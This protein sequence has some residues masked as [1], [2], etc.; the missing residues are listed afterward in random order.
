[1]LVEL[2]VRKVKEK[3]AS[4]VYQN[5]ILVFS[6]KLIISLKINDKYSII[7][8]VTL[9]YI[10]VAGNSYIVAESLK[11]FTTSRSIAYKIKLSVLLKKFF[12]INNF[13]NSCTKK[14][15]LQ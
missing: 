3:P 8:V 7:C 6:I 14:K 10:S 1:V 11:Y 12:K 2:E 13:Y 15:M 9:L 5:I 4:L